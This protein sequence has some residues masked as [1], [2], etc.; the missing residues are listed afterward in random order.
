MEMKQKSATDTSFLPDFCGTRIVFVVILLAEL[1]AILLSLAHSAG[2]EDWLL[3]LALYSL[4]IQWVALSCVFALC[5]LRRFF[6]SLPDYWAATWSY[7]TTLGTAA[8][9]TELTWQVMMRWSDGQF[10]IEGS[11]GAFF[12]RSLV[13][14]AIV[15]ALSLRYFYVQHQW[16]RQVEAEAEARFQALQSRIR[17]HFLFN[18]MNTIA[19]L[20][21][22]QPALAEES[23]EDLADLFRASLQDIRNTST[24]LDEISLCERYLRIEQHR[25][26]ERLKISWEIDD[27]PMQSTLPTLSLQPLLENAIYHGIEPLPDGG[28]ILI[29]SENNDDHFLITISNPV[30]ESG[31]TNDRNEGNHLALENIRQRLLAFFGPGAELTVTPEAASYQ[32]T[33][34]IPAHHENSDS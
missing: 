25:L 13:I 34:R 20:I 4:F 15:S 11:H 28:T 31:T 5:L 9:T 12:I 22:R 7:L 24:L 16:R 6:Q 3:E 2:G 27:L 33:I 8:L 17:P 1:L 23:I 10:Y 19:G 21:R 26:G 32:V 29:T 18:C 30:S 14:S